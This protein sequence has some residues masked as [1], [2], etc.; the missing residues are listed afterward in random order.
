MSYDPVVWAFIGI[1]LLSIEAFAIQGMGILFTGF[2]AICVGVT[3][4]NDMEALDG[5]IGS[6]LSY[7][8]G[9]TLMWGALLWMPLRHFIG[10]AR[11]DEFK[12]IVGTFGVVHRTFGRDEVGYINWSGSIVKCKIDEK[13]AAQEL[14]EK[15]HVKVTEVIDG[16][17]MVKPVREEMDNFKD[18]DTLLR[19]QE[20]QKQRERELAAAEAEKAANAAPINGIN[21][22]SDPNGMKQMLQD[23]K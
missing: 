16:I 20:E 1:T 6:Q 3:V 11:E 15:S 18:R 5:D 2:A 12:N 14:Q 21:P 9:Y 17:Y 22:G 23:R 4:Y 7:F 8:F 19:E 10:Y 13:S